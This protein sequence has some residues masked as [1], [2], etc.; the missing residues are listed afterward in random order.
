[1]HSFW[2][3]S[4]TAINRDRDFDINKHAFRSSGLGHSGIKKILALFDTPQPMTRNNYE[5]VGRQLMNTVKEVANDSMNSA[6]QEIHAKNKSCAVTDDNIDDT[7]VDDNTSIFLSKWY[8]KNLKLRIEDHFKEEVM[9]LSSPSTSQYILVG[10]NTFYSNPM[11]C[12]SVDE[13]I[14]YVC[15]HGNIH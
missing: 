11:T 7:S 5:K 2:T 10:K 4:K 13:N 15:C 14:R 9:F 8:R 1:M 12:L 6:A 3:S